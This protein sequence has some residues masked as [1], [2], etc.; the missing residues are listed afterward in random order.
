MVF[1]DLKREN[2]KPRFKIKDVQLDLSY[3][4]DFIVK[5]N[6]WIFEQGA[7]L[8][9]KLI[10]KTIDVLMTKILNENIQKSVNEFI[11][12]YLKNSYM[13]N[14][15]YKFVLKTVKKP[16]FGGNV[17]KRIKLFFET[18]IQKKHQRDRTYDS[19]NAIKIY[20]K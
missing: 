15:E 13:I 8:G 18:K 17:H 5:S 12:L 6:N 3:S 4:D 2:P 16:L 9:K 1:D 7:K 19:D 11:D 20:F 14:D 10:Q